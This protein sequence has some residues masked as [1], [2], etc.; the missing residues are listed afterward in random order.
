MKMLLYYNLSASLHSNDHQQMLN[1]TGSDRLSDVS[2][3]WNEWMRFFYL[4][5]NFSVVPFALQPTVRYRQDEKESVIGITSQMLIA[6]MTRRF[7]FNIETF[8]HFSFQRYNNV[9]IC[10]LNERSRR[11]YT[12][13][14]SLNMFTVLS[15][16]HIF[17][18]LIIYLYIF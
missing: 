10:Q 3:N 6:Y 15:A 16:F 13:T 18:T 7:H 17:S 2:W 4:L 12:Q 9:N 11:I 1:N 14:Q 5:L 8:Y